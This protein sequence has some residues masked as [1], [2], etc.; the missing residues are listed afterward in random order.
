MAAQV[1]YTLKFP[2]EIRAKDPKSGEA[3]VIETI[4]SVTHPVG[5]RLK[6]RDL[7]AVGE[8]DNDVDRTLLL[9][10]HFCSLSRAAMDDMDSEDIEHLGGVVQSFRSGPKTGPTS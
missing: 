2:I 6:G 4:T 5:I 7:R 10:A 1:T 8:A 3:Q 9:I